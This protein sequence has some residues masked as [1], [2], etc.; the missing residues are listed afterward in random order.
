MVGTEAKK[1]EIMGLPS[2]SYHIQ[3]KPLNNIN[4]TSKIVMEY[5]II[6]L[7]FFTRHV[8]MSVIT[9]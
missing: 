9:H 6:M 8:S 4:M 1:I 5:P 7:K 2:V 3:Y